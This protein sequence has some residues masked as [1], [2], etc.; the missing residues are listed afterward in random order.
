MHDKIW[1]QQLNN[2]SS[3]ESLKLIHLSSSGS[4]NTYNYVDGEMAWILLSDVQTE[5]YSS[6]M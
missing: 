2:F 4:P 3:S 1:H 5:M 6:T